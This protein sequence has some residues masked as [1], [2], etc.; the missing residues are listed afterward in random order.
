[1][2]LENT[3]TFRIDVF[4]RPVQEEFELIKPKKY[5]EYQFVP[6]TLGDQVWLWFE[7]DTKE[8]KE[9]YVATLPEKFKKFLSVFKQSDLDYWENWNK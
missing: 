1:M 9:I 8:E 6:Q 5:K 2:I 3:V 7:F 4:E